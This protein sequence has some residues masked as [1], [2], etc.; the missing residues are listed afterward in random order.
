MRIVF[1]GTGEIGVP[2]LRALLESPE[3]ELAGVVTQPDKRAGREQ[4]VQAPPIKAALAGSGL[5][6]L[7]PLRIKH[8]DAVAQIAALAPDV[9][10]VM[11]YGQ[12]LS[13]QVLETPVIAC[14]NLHASLLPRHRGAAPVQ[15]TIVAGDI[16]SGITVMYM[17]EGL[18]TGDILLQRTIDLTPEETGGSLHDRLGKIAPAALLDA[19]QLLAA[20]NAPRVSQKES[21]ATYA[22]KLEREHGRIDWREPAELIAR[23]IRAFDPWPGSFTAVRDARGREHKLKIFRAKVRPNA[24]TR[25]GEIIGHEGEALVVPTS[26]GALSLE[27]LQLEGAR[28]MTA[29]ELLRGHAWLR[30]AAL[31]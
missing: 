28:R 22:P 1:I 13:R 14:L 8:D 9:V 11:A 21:E 23:K 27:E 4:R 26:D 24:T 31:A 16:Q 6:V 30:S 25:P 18:D 15:A 12:I 10:V 5:R 7:Q 29:G 19:L 2:T 3:H 17:N 20:G